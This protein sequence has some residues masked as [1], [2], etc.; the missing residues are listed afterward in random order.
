MKSWPF[1]T[2]AV[3]VRQFD[4][5]NRVDEVARQYL[6]KELTWEEAHVKMAEWYG[7][8]GKLELAVREYYAISK[9]IPYNVSPVLRMGR[10]YLSA[11]KNAEAEGAFEKSLKIA[12]SLHAYQGL[13]FLALQKGNPAEATQ[14]LERALVYSA[15]VQPNDVLETQQ[16][17]AVALAGSGR[18]PEAKKIA[19]AMVASHPEYR[20]GRDLLRDIEGA[21][22]RSPV[23]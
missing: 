11:G 9:A 6:M 13:G 10:L 18:L 16:Y 2:T 5:K 21:M 8:N 1:T 23:R 14:M 20:E 12:P 19:E 3:S 15:G 4:P 17:L 22:Q 7:T